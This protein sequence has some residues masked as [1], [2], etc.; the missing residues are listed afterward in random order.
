MSKGT[1][2]FSEYLWLGL[3]VVAVILGWDAA[4]IVGALALSAIHQVAADLLSAPSHGRE[5]AE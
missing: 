1:H 4:Y 2:R 5:G 3:A